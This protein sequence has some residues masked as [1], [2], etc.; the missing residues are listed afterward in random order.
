M[1]ES[2]R[3]FIAVKVGPEAM[4][5]MARLIAAMSA[6]AGRG[7]KWVE[8]GGIHITLKFLGDTP[9]TL[10]PR[11]V[12]AMGRAAAAMRPLTLS[13]AET[14]AFPNARAPRVLWVGL[15]GDVE[16]L[17]ALQEAVE[18][19]VSPL[20]FPRE[21]R[22]FSPHV[23]IGRVRE[24]IDPSGRQQIGRA[25]ER[26]GLHG[27]Y[28]WVVEGVALVRSTLTPSGAVYTVIDTK[29]LSEALQ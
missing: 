20:G 7:V 5:E 3:T 14:G 21:S 6:Q 29:K 28:P 4:K 19:E 13:L 25:L 9:A 18:R 16:A 17:A 23:T 27:G 26:A 8:P 2:L 12:E 15:A 1:T 24:G 10:V 22:P 11:V